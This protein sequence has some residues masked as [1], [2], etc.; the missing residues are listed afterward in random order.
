[1]LHYPFFPLGRGD[2]N[3]GASLCPRFIRVETRWGGMRW[4]KHPR[5]RNCLRNSFRTSRGEGQYFLY[6]SLNL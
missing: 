4:Y 2:N 3:A 6:R 5:L 1:M